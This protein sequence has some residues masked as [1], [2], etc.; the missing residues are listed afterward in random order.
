GPRWLKGPPGVA[1]DGEGD[2]FIADYI[3]SDVAELKPDNFVTTVGSGVG[4][5][6]SVAVD[7]QGDVFIV[8][9]LHTRVVEVTP[10]VNVTVVG[11]TPTAL[12]LS[13][14]SQALTYGQS[15][16]LTA[17]VTVPKGAV[18]PGSGNGTV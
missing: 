16:T 6:T 10:R 3:G 11:P 5:P 4:D 1:V 7:G 8:D 15:E 12:T 13:V 9:F 18:L 17:T 14:T 2:V